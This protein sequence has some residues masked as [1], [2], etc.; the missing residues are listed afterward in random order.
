M[1]E[2]SQ[3]SALPRRDRFGFGTRPTW[4]TA[5]NGMQKDRLGYGITP[6]DILE[7]PNSLSVDS[8]MLLPKRN[9]QAKGD[10]DRFLASANDRLSTLYNK[11]RF[12]TQL[13]ENTTL[14]LGN[15]GSTG[16]PPIK[17]SFRGER[18]LWD[19]QDIVGA[20]LKWRF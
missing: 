18:D 5:L 6:Y 16:R 14:S 8:N 17:E 1:S 13:G 15:I 10:F 19:N 12:D 11:N 2:E 3:S 9:Q 4:M 20:K 7:A